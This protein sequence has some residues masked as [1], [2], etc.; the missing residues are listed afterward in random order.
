LVILSD[1]FRY[2]AAHELTRELNGNY[3]FDA[4]LTAQLSVLPSYTL[5]GTRCGV[6][7]RLALARPFL[8]A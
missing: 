6:N 2:E 4:A 1:A 8:P 5:L 7:G 3:R